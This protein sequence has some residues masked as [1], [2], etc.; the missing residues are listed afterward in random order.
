VFDLG[1]SE[2]G[3][4]LLV[5]LLVLGPK[6]MP[7]LA[8]D[9]GRWVGKARAL[10]REFQRSLEDMA[11]E[12]ELD[13]VKKQI[14]EAGREMR[15]PQLTKRLERE[16]DPGGELASAFDV[17]GDRKPTRRAAAEGE[18]A[19]DG[20]DGPRAPDAGSTDDRC[21]ADERRPAPAS[22]GAGER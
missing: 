10:A 3:I 4:V 13:D 20:G 7:K 8:R 6:E 1:W 19:N 11:R 17:E 16:V 5:A 21:D 12:A 18:T 15:R 9:L 14:D 22:S 2:M